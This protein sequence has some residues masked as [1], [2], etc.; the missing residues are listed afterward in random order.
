[1]KYQETGE[2]FIMSSNVVCTAHRTGRVGQDM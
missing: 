1:M 2:N